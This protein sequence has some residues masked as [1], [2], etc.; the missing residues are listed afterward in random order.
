MSEQR[1]MTRRK[2]LRGGSA[3]RMMTMTKM[4]GRWLGIRPCGG[5]RHRCSKGMFLAMEEVGDR[6]VS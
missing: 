1:T 3:L 4:R 2:D 5:M 6:E